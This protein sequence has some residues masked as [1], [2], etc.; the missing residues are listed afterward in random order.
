ME[1]KEY[2]LKNLIK[3]SFSKASKTYDS[4]SK[5]QK[6]VA[7]DIVNKNLECLSDLDENSIVADVGCGT[8]NVTENI[9][10]LYPN[11]KI[12]S[13]DL[14]TDMLKESKRKM[15]GQFITA[16]YDN[17]PFK[18]SSFD[19]VISSLTYQ[20]AKDGFNSFSEALRILKP[21]GCFIFS[22]LGEDSLF[23]MKECATEAYN[24]NGVEPNFV[25]FQKKEQV[26][27]KLDNAGFNNLKIKTYNNIKQHKNLIDLLKTLK[28]IGASNPH[29]AG[30]DKMKN[31]AA[32]TALKE[33]SRLYD[34]RY[35]LDGGVQATYNIILAHGKKPK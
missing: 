30:N 12:I 26:T 17:F 35:P 9:K 3:N 20:W 33:A 8:G 21:G 22:T 23:E 1:T 34:K 28:N 2:P 29:N 24:K 25:E 16:D 32:G 10:K 27:T 18:D 6:E 15:N 7:F 5:L 13:S 31:L 14:S 11:L 19:V 4:N